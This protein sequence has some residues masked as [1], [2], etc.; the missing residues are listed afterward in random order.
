MPDDPVVS[1]K[2]NSSTT[3][4]S[5]RGANYRISRP[6]SSR[7]AIQVEKQL[8]ERID[9]ERFDSVSGEDGVVDGNRGERIVGRVRSVVARKDGRNLDC[10]LNVE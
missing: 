8:G 6:M 7:R 9:F 4:T 2:F 10:L 5:R 1:T 3:S